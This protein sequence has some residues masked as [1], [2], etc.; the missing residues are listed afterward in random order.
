M[1]TRRCPR[2]ARGS[3]GGQVSM[4]EVRRI[5]IKEF[6]ESGYLQEANR[7]FFHPL[8]LALEVSVAE[9]GTETL[10]G[11]WDYRDD[12]EGIYF[13]ER[14]DEEKAIYVEAAR[15]AHEQSRAK[16]FGTATDPPPLQ[17]VRDVQPLDWEPS[18]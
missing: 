18:G 2:T 1:G 11:V 9:D 17:P 6:R 13:A 15:L 5:D 8:G 12:P 10:G 7:L 4:S 3:E 16:L 14:V